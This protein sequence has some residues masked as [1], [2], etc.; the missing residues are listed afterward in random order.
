MLNR[1]FLSFCVAIYFVF[2]ATIAH[3]QLPQISSGLSYL[4]SSQ[5]TEGFW[6]T[7]A[8]LVETYAATVSAVESMEL[9][10]H[11]QQ[12]TSTSDMEVCRVAT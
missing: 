3:A 2:F 12:Q 5:N 8:S 1:N 11:N 9:L 6:A 4:S 10:N 7:D